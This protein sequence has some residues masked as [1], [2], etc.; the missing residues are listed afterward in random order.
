MT[1]QSKRGDSSSTTD[2][3]KSKP[4]QIAGPCHHFDVDLAKPDPE[5][6]SACPMCMGRGCYTALHV[7]EYEEMPMSVKCACTNR[8]KGCGQPPT[9]SAN[10]PM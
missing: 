5:A 4:G 7:G 10:V 6:D 2:S 3:L 1:V 9:A 8:R